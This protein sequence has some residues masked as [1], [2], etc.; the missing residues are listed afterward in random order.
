MI[1]KSIAP[2]SAA[3]AASP[4]STA[5]GT[6]GLAVRGLHGGRYEQHCITAKKDFITLH[7]HNLARIGYDQSITLP[8]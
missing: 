2:P 8:V 3:S 6:A 4:L 7:D 5:I 1:S